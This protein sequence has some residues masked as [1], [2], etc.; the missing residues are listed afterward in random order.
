MTEQPAAVLSDTK[1]ALLE[2]LRQGR[3]VAENILALPADLPKMASFSQ[4]RLWFV[5]QLNPDSAAYTMH[6]ALLVEGVLDST[7]LGRAL[8]LVCSRHSLLQS[9]FVYQQG[10]LLLQPATAPQ[11]EQIDLQEQQPAKQKELLQQH[12]EA[13]AATRFDLHHGPLVRFTLVKLAAERHALLFAIHHII[14]DEWSNGVFWQELAAAYTH[15]SSGSLLPAHSPIRYS[16]YAAWQRQQFAGAHAERQLN[17]WRDML[18]G[19]LPTLHL[20]TDRLRPAMQ[21]YHGSFTRRTLPASLSQSLLRFAQSAATT[22]FVVMLA[23]YAALLSRYT[24]QHDLLIGTPVANRKRQETANVIGL[25]INTIVL[26]AQLEETTTF[27]ALVHQLRARVLAAL[28]HQ[29][30]PFERLVEVLQPHRDPSQHILF[31]T[32]LVWNSDP[33]P[34]FAAPGITTQPLT[35]DG[36]VAK[37]DLTLFAGEYAGRIECAAEFNTDL[38]DTAT[39]ERLLTH[40]ETLLQHALVQPEQSVRAI[41]LLDAAER[42][43]VLDT[44]NTTPNTVPTEQSIQQLFEMWVDRTPHAPALAWGT[45]QRTYAELEHTANQLAHLLRAAGVQPGVSVV[46]CLERS[47]DLLVAMLA[48]L[49]AGG[50]YVPLDPAYPGE[51]L[52]WIIRE[53]AAPL[54]LTQSQL[55]DSIPTGIAQLIVIDQISDL[56]NRQP[57]QRPE[58]LASLDDRAYIIYTSGSTGRPKGVPVSQRQLLF[59]THARLNYYQGHNQRFLLLSSAAFDSSVAG[60]FGTLCSGGTLCLPA[61]REEQDIAK[62]AALIEQH[63]ITDTLCL[64]S[65]YQVLLEYADD[66]QLRSLRTVIVAGEACLPALVALHT[67]RLP[68]AKLYN[69]YGPTEGTVWATVQHVEATGSGLVPIGRP[70]AHMQ[71]YILDTQQQPVPIGIPGELYLAGAGVVDGYFNRPDLTTERFFELELEPGLRPRLYRTGDLARWLSDGTIQFLGRVDQQLKLR[72]FRI[73][74][75]EIEQALLEHPTIQQAAVVVWSPPASAPDDTTLLTY[76]AAMPI[77]KA[78]NL[79]NAIESASAGRYELFVEELV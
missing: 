61:P 19:E 66:F 53:V 26:R 22:P 11:L 27:Q 65:L 25:F 79:L 70:I 5:Q 23:A 49:K 74:P 13:H 43:L 3:G 54:V 17:Y 55:V 2:R 76:L 42:A 29:D 18:A 6:Q 12:A 38:F 16:D 67:E 52:A 21:S 8:E 10:R 39:I 56:L 58:R 14:S 7:V 37:F 46:L 1:R 36:H 69:E 48:T 60:I 72:G 20:P 32:M 9:A 50:A 24:G 62:I 71:A 75:G 40:L 4:E 33:E 77:D 34:H 44:W 59:S 15:C 51:R 41:P 68:H 31:Q 30:L 57:A 78:S 64:P 45:Y 28:E 47:P 35:V 63:A 73:E